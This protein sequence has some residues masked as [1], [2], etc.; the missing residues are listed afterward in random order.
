MT[1]RTRRFKK[2]LIAALLCLSSLSSVGQAAPTAEHPIESI[3][4]GKEIHIFGVIHP[5]RFN[6]AQGE[7][8]RYHFLVWNGGMSPNALIQTPA[9]DLAFHDALAAL[10][11]HPGD[12]LSMESWTER[13]EPNNPASREKVTGSRLEVRLTWADNPTGVTLDQVWQAAVSSSSS[14]APT[15][16]HF[17]GNRERWF[18]KVPLVR[19]PGCLLC[20]YSCPSGKVSNGAL[21][22]HDYVAMPSRFEANLAALPPDGTPVI[23][24]IRIV[25]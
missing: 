21:S 4:A 17:G 13:N 18:N 20:L 11:A 5:Q 24:T 25:S 1:K 14:T 19:R 7:E 15:E 10:G 8:S 9:D 2:T 6:A 12:N 3:A 16:W 23:V 22:I